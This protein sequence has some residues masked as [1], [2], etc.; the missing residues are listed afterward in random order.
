MKLNSAVS[1]LLAVAMVCALTATPLRAQTNLQTTA[2]AAAVS[3]PPAAAIPAAPNPPPEPPTPPAGESDSAG[4]L[5]SVLGQLIPI[6]GIVMGCSIP[7][8]IVISVCYFNHRKTKILHETV[9]AMV[10][11]GVPIPPELLSKSG[12]DWQ[13]NCPPGTSPF[14]TAFGLHQPRN[15]LR[16]G[17]LMT[18]LGVGLVILIGSP[19]AIVLFLGIA[20]VLVGIFQKKNPAP[21]QPP[22]P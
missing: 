19:G 13:Q 20:F 8:V 10:E 7:I 9:R 2:T 21:E 15:D 12:G 1:S 5:S 22:K 3:L 4:L 16:T 17:L 18:G 6:V 14:Q 11:K